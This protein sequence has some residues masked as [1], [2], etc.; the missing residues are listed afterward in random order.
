MSASVLCEY[1]FVA[2]HS[3]TAFATMLYPGRSGQ[4]YGS[5][6]NMHAA[7]QVQVHVFRS[8]GHCVV[9][10]Q[11]LL[12]VGTPPSTERARLAAMHLYESRAARLCRNQC[13]S[14][15]GAAMWQPFWSWTNI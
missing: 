11:L 15:A 3:L 6:R 1:Q 10:A 7:A 8:A 9:S 13:M 2:M 4:R 5:L 12:Q 14:A